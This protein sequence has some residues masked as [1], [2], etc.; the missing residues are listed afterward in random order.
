[1]T[2]LPSYEEICMLPAA[3]KSVVGPEFIDSNQ[4]MNIAHYFAMGARGAQTALEEAGATRDYL[5]QHLLGFF[6][7]EH[8]LRYYAELTEG[9]EMSV[10]PRV[11][12]RSDKAIHLVSLLVNDSQGRLANTVEIVVVHVDLE[13]RRPTPM[14]DDLALSLD[15]TLGEHRSLA[16]EAPL[17]GSMGV[18]R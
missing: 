5:A 15:T 4:H 7:V 14:P 1:M 13:T 17:C 10:H 18:R 8:H 3:I 11:L 9:E 12:E 16:W 2:A 6:T